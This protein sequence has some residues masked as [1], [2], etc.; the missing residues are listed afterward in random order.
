MSVS[1]N[2]EHIKNNISAVCGRCGR[3]S[4]EVVLS[5]ATK[6]VSPESIIEAVHS[7]ITILGENRV[8]EARGKIHAVSGSVSWHMIGH[9]QKNKV[10]AAIE[11]FDMI[12]SVDSLQLLE[13]INNAAVH[14]GRCIDVL[15]EVNISREP[16]KYGFLPEEL[17]EAFSG[18]SRFN[19][20]SVRGLMT[21]GAYYKDPE[22]GRPLYNS[23]KQLF[24]EYS[25]CFHGNAGVLSMGMSN[26]YLIA[27]EEGAT[28][29]RLGSAIFGER[30]Y[31]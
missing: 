10:N 31:T 30:D 13:R 9:L 25:S 8:Q 3:D 23:M 14:R 27:I 4:E 24:N 1:R 22:Q 15:I 11:L 28:M 17:G 18:I 29:V 5:A 6:T 16:S 2:I 21:L 7:G 19:S 26:D 12:Q 20:V